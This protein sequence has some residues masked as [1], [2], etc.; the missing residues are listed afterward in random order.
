MNKAE[1]NHLF[2]VE[3]YVIE[4]GSIADV[5]RL[6]AAD[7]NLPQN[8]VDEVFEDLAAVLNSDG[9]VP[10]DITPGNPSSVKETAEILTLISGFKEKH[11]ALVSKMAGFLISRQKNDGGFAETLNLNHL[12]EDRYGS[13]WGEDFYP[14]GKSVTWLTGKALEALCSIGF[15]DESRIR[16][17]RD[18]LVYS[19]NE[20]GFWPD[21]IGQKT[22]DPLASGNIISGLASAG[23]KPDSKVYVN[24]RAALF[25]HL[26]DSVESASTHDMM[27]LTAVGSPQNEK[28][29]EVINSGLQLILGSQRNDGGWALLGSKKSDPELSSIFALVLNRCSKHK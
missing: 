10:F 19:Q 18:F 22:S 12:I 26:K 21:Y 28:E 6:V 5:I 9:G 23:V 8:T 1:S 11:S 2:D 15:E 24:A 4:N 13:T 29:R 14:V 17:A 16:R 27:D 7:C 20:D 3:K 25:Q